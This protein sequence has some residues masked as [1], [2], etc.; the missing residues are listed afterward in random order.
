MNLALQRRSCIQ[1]MDTTAGKHNNTNRYIND[2]LYF[3]IKPWEGGLVYCS[4][5]NVTR[6]SPIIKGRHGICSN[7]AIRG[8]QLVNFGVRDLGLARGAVIR[9]L[10]GNAC[11]GIAPTQDIWYTERLLIESSPAS[12]PDEVI[13]YAVVNLVKK[14]TKACCLDDSDPPEGLTQP[15]ELQAFLEALCRAYGGKA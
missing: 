11:A 5:V 7:H 6:F 10:R 3:V 8:L 2:F 12:F 4:G 14:V 13:N 9:P 15:S 1:H